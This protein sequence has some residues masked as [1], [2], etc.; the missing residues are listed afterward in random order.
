MDPLECKGD[1]AF[2][3]RCDYKKTISINFSENWCIHFFEKT[4][5][6]LLARK[7]INFVTMDF[8][9]GLIFK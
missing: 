3:I 9:Q 8:Y 4:P 7:D 2:A 6:F 5:Y 1:F